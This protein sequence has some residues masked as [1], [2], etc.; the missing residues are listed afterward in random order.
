M[1]L[2]FYVVDFVNQLRTKNKLTITVHYEK[3]N[4]IVLLVHSVMSSWTI[5][6]ELG[7]QDRER[8][9]YHCISTRT[10]ISKD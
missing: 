8:I 9:L 2:F 1:Q 10:E 3:G 7:G 6:R 5:V 4:R